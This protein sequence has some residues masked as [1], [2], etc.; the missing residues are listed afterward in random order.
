MLTG[1]VL[2]VEKLVAPC[3]TISAFGEDPKVAEIESN[4]LKIYCQY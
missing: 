3:V 4:S 1:E 2:G